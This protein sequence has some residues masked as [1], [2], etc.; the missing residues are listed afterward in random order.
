MRKSST[1]TA[2]FSESTVKLTNESNQSVD[3]VAKNLG[4]NINAF[5]AEL[6]NTAKQRLIN[7]DA[8]TSTFNPCLKKLP[9]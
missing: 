6:L 1:Y 4:I 7:L 3:Q 5:Q 8:L 9:T 2:A